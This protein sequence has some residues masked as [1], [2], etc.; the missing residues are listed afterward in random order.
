MN[1]KNQNM[2]KQIIL[3]AEELFLEKGFTR[4]S[5]TEIAKRAGCNQALVHYYFRT[6]ENLFR[7]LF[8]DKF[9]MFIESITIDSVCERG[10]C[11]RIENIVNRHIDFLCNNPGLPLLMLSEISR[12]REKIDFV[13]GKMKV[14]S[15]HIVGQLELDIKKEYEEG[16]IRQVN[17]FDLLFSILSL[18]IFMFIAQPMVMSVREMT[19]EDYSA[20][21][22]SRREEIVKT[23]IGGIYL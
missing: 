23:V 13:F 6:K 22:T 11:E 7:K 21:I 19:E 4:T 16:K 17:A 10:L 8:E 14:H 9:S 15:V 20:F 12:N 3:A 1:E 5:T 2:E 18:N